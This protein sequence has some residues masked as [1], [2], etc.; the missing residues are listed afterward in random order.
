LLLSLWA[1]KVRYFAE[2]CFQFEFCRLVA[3]A[4][5]LERMSSNA[6]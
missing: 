1:I 2:H 3:I 5:K 6:T 4:V